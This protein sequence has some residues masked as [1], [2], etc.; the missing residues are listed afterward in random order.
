MILG[1]GGGGGGI[2]PCVILELK[3]I[4]ISVE[5]DHPVVF[6]AKLLKGG[7]LHFLNGK[8]GHLIWKYIDGL[9]STKF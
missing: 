8:S 9:S 3:K 7:I 4:K 1:R 5:T 2:P 6:D